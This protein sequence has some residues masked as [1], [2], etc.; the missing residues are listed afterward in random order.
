[1]FYGLPHVLKVLRGSSV[2]PVK[3]CRWVSRDSHAM[4]ADDKAMERLFQGKEGVYFVD[5]GER[6]GGNR[7][8]GRGS[9]EGNVG[10][11]ITQ[12]LGR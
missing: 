1:M 11:K 8:R 12:G 4:V 10:F 6:L 9:G 7:G 5:L 2:I 3:G